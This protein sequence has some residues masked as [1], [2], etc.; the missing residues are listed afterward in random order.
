MSSPRLYALA[1]AALLSGG[2][3]SRGRHSIENDPVALSALRAE[4][5]LVGSETTWVTR[6]Q[7][8]ELIGRT[9]ADLV[10]LQ[11]PLDREAA[12]IHRVFPE[13]TIA[14][15]VVTVRRAVAAGKPFVSAAP[16]PTTVHL[17]VVE[18][19]LPDPN[20]KRDLEKGSP[21]AALG[22]GLLAER[23]PTL[24]VVRAWL[25]AHA[26]AVMAAPARSAEATGEF[27]DP[28][29]PMWAQEVIPSLTAD[30][31]V[32]RFLKLLALN[33]DD[34]I[35]IPTYFAMERTPAGD[36]R[37]ALRAGEGQRGGGAG[38]GTGGR[39]GGG[40]GMGGRGG[41]GGGGRGG[42]GGRGGARGGGGGGMPSRSQDDQSRGPQGAALFDA[43]SVLVG[44][45][46]AARLGY[47]VI[48]EMID[49]HIF[50][51]P[52]D[53]VFKRHKAITLAQMD[54]DWYAWFFDRSAAVS[55]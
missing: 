39:G 45:Y 7:G 19:V 35:P 17:P 8:Y 3:A 47:E 55:R 46:L 2:C 13:D 6:G 53:E 54:L 20:A 15:L 9:K 10:A 5:R 43:Q 1:A 41:M 33:P 21:A 38:G 16:Y 32:D 27:E 23:T 52:L 26:S 30:S 29:I 36:P 31:L 48:G 4:L 44:R 18:V 12:M 42:M 34:M 28:R 51:R 24:P 22:I 40:G 14:P 49:A 11:S 50:N 37:I 25:S